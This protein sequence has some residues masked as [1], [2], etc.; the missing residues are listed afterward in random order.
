MLVSV[1]ETRVFLYIASADLEYYV[2]P[3]GFCLTEV[4]LPISQVL[5][6]K[7]ILPHPQKDLFNKLLNDF[8]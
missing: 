6:L 8:S 5:G 4:H 3:D 2:D 7:P 1:I